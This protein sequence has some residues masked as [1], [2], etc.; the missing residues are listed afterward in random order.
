VE[1]PWHIEPVPFDEELI[2]LAEEAVS[3]VAGKSHRLALETI[4]W[5]RRE[6][7]SP[8]PNF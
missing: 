2:G 1:R 8:Q 7:E 4:R 3:E 5:R 6:R